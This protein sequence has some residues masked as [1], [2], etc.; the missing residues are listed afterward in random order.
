MIREYSEFSAF[1]EFNVNIIKTSNYK[2]NY[3]VF[4][5]ILFQ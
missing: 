3:F 4:V 2:V 1:L 5:Q